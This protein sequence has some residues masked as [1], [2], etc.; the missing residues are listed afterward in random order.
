MKNTNIPRSI[1]LEQG[2]LS[3]SPNIGDVDFIVR[4]MQDDEGEYYDVRLDS[5]FHCPLTA[6]PFIG[7]AIF[8][9]ASSL[10]AETFSSMEEVVQA[11][12]EAIDE[13][14][15]LLEED[16]PVDEWVQQ[17]YWADAYN[18]CR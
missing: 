9:V 17:E 16:E 5:G 14:D 15:E 10:E 2:T 1:L 3:Y 12:Q 18:A 6:N 7:D 11:V 13:M 8:K 4:H